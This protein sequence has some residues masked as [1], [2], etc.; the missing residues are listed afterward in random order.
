MQAVLM[1][2][3]SVGNPMRRGKG[4]SAGLFEWMAAKHPHIYV[5]L[6]IEVLPLIVADH[7]QAEERVNAHER[8]TEITASMHLQSLL[9]AIVM[10]PQSV[11][12]PAKRGKGGLPGYMEWLAV[13]Y[14]RIYVSLLIKFKPLLLAE[15]EKMAEGEKVGKLLLERVLRMLDNIQAEE[16]LG[17][18]PNGPGDSST[19]KQVS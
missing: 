8:P 2:P 4:G 5:S 16:A 18:G 10:A 7:E 17:I 12:N 9:Q 14:P 6:L 15:Q 1:A 13:K 19:T 3:Q 11:G